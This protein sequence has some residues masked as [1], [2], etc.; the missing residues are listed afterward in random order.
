MPKAECE[1]KF[2][3]INLKFLKKLTDKYNEECA[4]A[5]LLTSGQDVYQV[6]DF[7]ASLRVLFEACC[8]ELGV[9][10]SAKKYYV[11]NQDEPYAQK[12]I[13]TILEG[14]NEKK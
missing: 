8:D 3:V 13:D 10:L 6:E 1:E 5:N 4:K 9:N 12:V 14:E 7:K 2:I 11:C